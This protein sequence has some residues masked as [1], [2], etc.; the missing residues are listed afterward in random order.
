MG[1]IDSNIEVVGLIELILEAGDSDSNIEVVELIELISI[2]MHRHWDAK[3]SSPTFGSEWR[4]LRSS[5]GSEWRVAQVAE[6][7]S[8]AGRCGRRCEGC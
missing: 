8:S 5:L 2:E 1:D 3:N 7:Y 6:E 4:G